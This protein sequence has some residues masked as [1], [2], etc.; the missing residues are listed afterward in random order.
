MPL[1]EAARLYR[2]TPDTMLIW[3]RQECFTSRIITNEIWI[4][5]EELESA[6]RRR[7]GQYAETN[8]QTH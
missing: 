6:L 8:C 3:V 4:S 1:P 2:V 7:P 5:R